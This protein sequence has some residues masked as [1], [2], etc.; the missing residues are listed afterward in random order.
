MRIQYIFP[1]DL[2]IV[3]PPKAASYSTICVGRDENKHQRVLYS[4]FYDSRFA[5][6][7]QLDSNDTIFSAAEGLVSTLSPENQR[8]LRRAE[9]IDEYDKNN[10]H[11]TV[12]QIQGIARIAEAKKMKQKQNKN[13]NI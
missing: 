11:G 5:F 3:S 2:S 12:G 8:I 9:P 1:I 10:K 7:F 4:F 6:G 13:E